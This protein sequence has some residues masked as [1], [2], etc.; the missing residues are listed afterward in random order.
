M[1]NITAAMFPEVTFSKTELDEIAKAFH[2]PCV[3][4]YLKNLASK[5]I[6]DIVHSV[7]TVLEDGTE[8]KPESYLR[9][10][11]EVKGGLA[12]IETLLSMQPAPQD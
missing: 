4:K 9:R 7:P 1:I 6:K 12:A 8:E 11:S 3:Q 10:V 5:Q 2:T